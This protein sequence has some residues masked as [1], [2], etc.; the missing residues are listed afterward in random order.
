MF[1]RGRKAAQTI[2]FLTYN[3]EGL[4]SLRVY[5][6]DVR[7]YISDFDIIVLTETF[8]SNFPAHLFPLHDSFVSN[9]VKLSDEPTARLCGGIAVLVGKKIVSLVTR[10]DTEYDNC[11]VLRLSGKLTG[12]QSDCVLIGIYLPPQKSKYYSDTDIYNG[13]YLLENCILDVF[14]SHGDL[15]F[16]IMGDLNARTGSANASEDCLP[17]DVI[18]MDNMNDNDVCLYRRISDDNVINDFGQYLLCVC[19]QFNLIILNGIVSGNMDGS[20]TY[21]SFNGSSTI[22]YCIVSRP[23]FDKAV[24]LTVGQRIE[25]KHMPVEL[26]LFS[27]V[28]LGSKSMKKSF[29]QKFQWDSTKKQEYFNVFKTESFAVK[30]REA[31]DLIDSDLGKALL[32][33]YDIL[34]LAA[35]PMLKTVIVGYTGNKP[36]FDKECRQ[37]RQSVRCALRKLR[38]SK[39]DMMIVKKD[40][41]V[42]RIHYTNSRKEYKVLLKQKQ[43]DYKDQALRM[44]VDDMNSPKQFWTTLKNYIGRPVNQCTISEEEWF[45]HFSTVFQ[46]GCPE[47]DLG[48]VFAHL[49]SL[50]DCSCLDMD[51][52]ILDQDITLQEVL[53]AISALKDNKAA[54]PDGFSGEFYKFAAPE[55]TLFLTSFFNRLFQTGSF[56]FEWSEAIIQPIHKKGDRNCPD[57][58][59][60]ISL[61]SVC[62]KLY[63]YILNRRLTKWVEEHKLLDE[64]QA[65]FSKNYSTVD[66]IFTL[67][68]LIQKQFCRDGKVYC[69]FIDFKKAFDL[70]DRCC[71]WAILKK[72]GIEGRMYKAIQSMYGVVKARVRVGGDLTN[73]F[74]CPKGLRQGDVCSPVLFSLFI[75][76]LAQ[77]IVLRGKHGISLTPEQIQIMILLFADDVLLL[78]HTIIGLQQ[79]LNILH[80][81]A[82]RLGLVV[83]MDKSKIIVFRKGGYLSARE[84]WV[85]NG[86]ILEIVN[87]YKYLGVY[88]STGLSFSCALKDMAARAKKGVIGILR[89]LWSFGN[90]SPQ[91]FFKLFDCQIQPILTYGSEA[92]GLIADHSI[93]ERVH[94]F[95]LKRFL[96]VSIRTP[97][98]L[99]YGETGRYPLFINVYVRQIKYW[100][101]LT[102]MS[103][104]RIPRKCYQMLYKLH[105]ND[106]TNWVSSVCF[107]LYRYGFGFVWEQQGVCNVK[108]FLVE[109]KQRLIDCYA[110]DWHYNIITNERYAF[111]SSLK[112]SLCLTEY[113]SSIHHGSIRKYL[114]RLRLGVS[115]LNCHVKRFYGTSRMALDCPFCP[116]N[117]ETE[118]HFI[119]LCPK[120][121][122]LRKQYIPFKFHRRPC[123]FKLTLLLSSNK[124]LVAVAMYINKALQIRTVHTCK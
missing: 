2:S 10:I 33:F 42:L 31:Y 91:M 83:N 4:R 78:S 52:G 50:S 57:N 61:L 51:G 21:I 69:A 28:A 79:Q 65:G 48:G 18:D 20:F 119:L 32:K 49:D 103:E 46:G 74:M 95:A 80:D 55:L 75:N 71:L 76:E 99:V 66:H 59:R 116:G 9:G 6:P 115:P 15:P 109:F 96:N 7:K 45:E 14:E 63:S 124:H 114:T 121:L 89:L 73:Y 122:A 82:N 43:N 102:R 44:L 120:Y 68:S 111:Y 94:L 56:P 54:G 117:Q 27:K 24:R 105:C 81:T 1:Q 100:L 26:E 106:K 11:V 40:I 29:V 108:T 62:S 97:N 101:S 36:W 35:A 112:Q 72:N 60:G 92:W 67:L 37:K 88:F 77:E 98:A 47:S 84:R 58:Y 113:L 23:I 19:E 16:I 86:Q 93:I 70:V 110:Q 12:Y 13:V 53:F 25:S 5:Q 22:D 30:F 107:T 38:Q 104:D 64:A 85:Y 3:I 87:Q 39:K 90:Q 118:Y 123:M 34:T 41:D 17:D 8:T